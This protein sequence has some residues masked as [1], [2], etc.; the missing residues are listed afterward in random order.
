MRRSRAPHMTWGRSAILW[1]ALWTSLSAIPSIAPPAH[2]Q[3]G[4]SDAAIHLL[5][6]TMWTTPKRPLIRIQIQINN[7]G[8]QPIFDA[9]VGW[10]LGPKVVSRVQYETALVNG[11]SFAAAADTVFR[12][13]DLGPGASI[14]VPI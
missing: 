9:V 4:T 8:D 2:A 3:L 14:S 7:V 5:F 1:V 12:A 13:G 6:Q 10:R 11:P